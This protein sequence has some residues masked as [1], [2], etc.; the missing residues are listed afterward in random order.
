MVDRALALCGLLT[1]PK[2]AQKSLIGPVFAVHFGVVGAP[3]GVPRHLCAVGCGGRGPAIYDLGPA[4]A[5]TGWSDEVA[6]VDEDAIDRPPRAHH[7]VTAGSGVD[8][9]GGASCVDD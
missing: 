1:K 8:R 2:A 9:R 5:A 6:A 4:G 3:V 7:P